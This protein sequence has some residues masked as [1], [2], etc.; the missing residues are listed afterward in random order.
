MR[1]VAIIT[2]AA[3]AGALNVPPPERSATA[4]D[5]TP[6]QARAPS[7]HDWPQWGRDG[8]HNAVSPEKNV[9][10][11]FLLTLKD[12]QGQFKLPTRYVAWSANLGTRTVVPPVIANG[13]VWCCSNA[14]PA[15]LFGI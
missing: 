14:R 13:L 12:E 6:V 3:V 1:A 15:T 5:G 8:T 4:Q 7:A 11:D 10:I 2:L 9:S